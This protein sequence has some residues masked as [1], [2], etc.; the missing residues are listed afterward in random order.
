MSKSD[1]DNWTLIYTTRQAH[2]IEI[3]VALLKENEIISV[4]VNKK[5]SA[6]AHLGE[7]ELYVHVRDEIFSKLIIE[8]NNL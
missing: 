2:K 6:H 3:I 8:Q 1:L 7:I 5:D 4:S